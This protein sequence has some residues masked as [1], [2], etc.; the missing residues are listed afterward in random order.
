MIQQKTPVMRI[1]LVHGFPGFGVVNLGAVE[2]EYF[3]DVA[4]LLTGLGFDVIIPTMDPLG[5]V[6]KRAEQLDGQIPPGQRVH[7]IGHSAGGLDARF[8]VSPGGRG[9]ATRVASI[10]TICTPHRGTPIATVASKLAG[11]TLLVLFPQAV[12]AVKNL[13]PDDMAAFNLRVP[14]ATDAGVKY[15]S[16]A[17]DLSLTGLGALASFFAL[18][19]LF[20]QSE[21]GKNDGWVSVTS[22]KRGELK[23]VLPTDHTGVVGWS[24]S[25]PGERPGRSSFEHLALYRRIADDLASLPP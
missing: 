10:T 1:V 18:P 22:A 21:E 14:D 6:E 4:R 13:T 20:I 23:G 16:Y 11:P 12:E 19:H 8:L 25:A 7:I 15:F 17:A 5:T 2:I 3:R 9:Q 24:F